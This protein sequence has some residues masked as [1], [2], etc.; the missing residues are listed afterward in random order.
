MLIYEN[1]IQDNKAAFIKKLLQI[2]QN[3][4]IDPNWLMIVM[5]S[6]SAFLPHISNPKNCVGTTKFCCVG[7]IQF[8]PPSQKALG[9]SREQLQK[10]SNLEQLDLVE[11]YYKLNGK[12][13]FKDYTD[14][15]LY[16]FYPKALLEKWSDTKTFPQSVVAANP[17]FDMD[18]NNTLSVG[19]FRNYVRKKVAKEGHLRGYWYVETAA[20]KK[21][22]GLAGIGIG[23]LMV[24]LLYSA[25]QHKDKMSTFLM[26]IKKSY[27]R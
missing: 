7:L 2:S 13:I 27:P 1:Y 22:I 8:C 25:Y 19:E 12:I 9:I 11:S 10:M 18:K 16:T 3:L 20:E 23:F 24:L 5:Y 21:K 14:L 17:I 4:G 6:E 15:Y 26:K